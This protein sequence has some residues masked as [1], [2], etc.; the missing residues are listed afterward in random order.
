M[1]SPPRPTVAANVM[2]RYPAATDDSYQMGQ[3]GSVHEADG[4]ARSNSSLQDALG[5]HT[6]DRMAL[7]HVHTGR[8]LPPLRTAPVL[9]AAMDVQFLE[10]RA[11]HV[12]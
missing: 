8:Y 1:I 9:A 5:W 12:K 6:Q 2:L 10:P 11:I 7:C 3:R 4:T